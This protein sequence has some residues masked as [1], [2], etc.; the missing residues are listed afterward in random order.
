MS[1]ID[2]AAA[3]AEAEGG[4]G[5]APAGYRLPAETHVGRVRLQVAGLERSLAWYGEVLGMRVL[6]RGDG[7]ATLGAG[8]GAP[9][10]ELHERPGAA[11]VPH[12]GRLG[13]YHFAILLPDRAALGRFVAHLGAVGERF[14]ASDHLV[15]EATYLHDPDG[16]GIEVYADRPR[17]SWRATGRELRMDTTPMDVRSVVAAAGGEAWAGMPAGTTIGHVHL[18]AGSLDRAAEFYHAALGLD[19]MVWSYPG[20]LFLSAGGYHHH[21]GLN[22]WAGPGARPPAEDEARL[23][24]WELVVPAADDVDAAARS[25]ADAGFA[26]RDGRADDPWGTTLRIVAAG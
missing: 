2:F 9:L 6:A 26:S 14:G 21:L 22:T 1:N 12:R 17:E 15:S 10:V 3:P 13:L 25:L 16:L 20:A 5:I 11:P 7:R 23:L 24:E 18:H 4:Y 8:D 19:A